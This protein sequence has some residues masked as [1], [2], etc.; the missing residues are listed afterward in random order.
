MTTR[1]KIESLRV[2]PI[3]GYEWECDECHYHWAEREVITPFVE[4]RVVPR[5]C[6]TCHT[7]ITED[8]NVDSLGRPS[9][10]EDLVSRADVLAVLG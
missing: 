9:D 10:H 8:G 2:H 1:Q 6:D 4:S 7:I 3:S 5:E